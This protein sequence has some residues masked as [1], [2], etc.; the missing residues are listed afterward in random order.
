MNSLLTECTPTGNI[1]GKGVTKHIA[2]GLWQANRS[3]VIVEH[4][5]CTQFQQSDVIGEAVVGIL[6]QDS[7]FSAFCK[8]FTF[9]Y[10][11]TSELEKNLFCYRT[12]KPI[13]VP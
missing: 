8:H 1:A 12:T 6:L 9:R 11:V 10:V 3:D 13:T 5:R 2:F 7:T 4:K